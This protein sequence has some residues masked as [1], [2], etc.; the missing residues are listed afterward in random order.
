MEAQKVVPEV[1]A[2]QSLPAKVPV[3]SAPL[4]PVP[5]DAPP[6]ESHMLC[7][8]SGFPPDFFEAALQHASP[9]AGYHLVDMWV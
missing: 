5:N 4:Q 8:S 9:L 1:T 3:Q 7:Y 6:Q 2:E